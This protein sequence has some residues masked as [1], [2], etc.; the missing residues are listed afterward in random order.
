[1][2][3]IDDSHRLNRAFKVEQG[4]CPN[5]EKVEILLTQRKKVLKLGL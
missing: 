3:D 1:L 4:L 2:G 5:G